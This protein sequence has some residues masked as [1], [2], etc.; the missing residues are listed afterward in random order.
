V[1]DFKRAL[2]DAKFVI[3]AD[4]TR[5]GAAGVHIARQIRKL[6]IEEQLKSRTRV[7]AGGDITEVTLS[8]GNGALGMTQVSEI[9]QK[10][11]AEFVGLLP[12]ELQNYTVFVIGTLPQPSEAVAAFSSFLQ[13]PPVRDVIKTKGMQPGADS[14]VRG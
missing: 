1:A 14:A 7:A 3:Y 6:G 9:V 8:L 10:K 13:S 5:G 11:G 12:D 2:L 4:P